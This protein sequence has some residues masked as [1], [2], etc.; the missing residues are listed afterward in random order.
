MAVVLS[1]LLIGF[2]C[3]EGRYIVLKTL[4]NQVV[5]PS[6]YFHSA[7]VLYTYQY[8]NT[9]K[10]MFEPCT[11]YCHIHLM[12]TMLSVRYESKMH[13][14]ISQKYK[15]FIVKNLMCFNFVEV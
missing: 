1:N 8:Y 15:I 5:H 9:P 7:I 4:L 12:C 6:E 10:R 14:L 11:R 13:V 3:S 2:L